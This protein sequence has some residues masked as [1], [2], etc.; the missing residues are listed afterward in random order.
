[1]ASEI[2]HDKMDG[3]HKVENGTANSQNS[4]SQKHKIASD[5]LSLIREPTLMTQNLFLRA[6]H[7]NFWDH[8]FQRLKMIDPIIKVSDCVS[9]HL[10]TR[11]FLMSQ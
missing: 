11:A 7:Q 5:L 8:H 1:M 6:N 9:R 10:S 4:S 2:F 3:F